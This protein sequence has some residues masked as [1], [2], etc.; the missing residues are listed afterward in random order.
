M[1]NLLVGHFHLV[2]QALAQLPALEAAHHY[3]F[4]DGG[5]GL[6]DQFFYCDRLIA[7]IGLTRKNDFILELFEATLDDLLGDILRLAFF[8]GTR[9]GDF[10]F[11]LQ[12]TGR[13]ILGFEVARRGRSNLQRELMSQFTE[14]V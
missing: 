9:P 5:D 2:V 4:A 8:F 14:F 10:R 7:D 11:M 12:H 1:T 13:N 3:I 6:Q